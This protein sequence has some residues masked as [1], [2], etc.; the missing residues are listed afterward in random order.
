[1]GSLD[2]SYKRVVANAAETKAQTQA[3]I[4]RAHQAYERQRSGQ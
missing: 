3:A 1:L 2:Q 4:D